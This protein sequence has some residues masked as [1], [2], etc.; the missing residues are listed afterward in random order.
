ML[1]VAVDARVDAYLAHA[2]KR[3]VGGESWIA[4]WSIGEMGTVEVSSAV[5][6]KPVGEKNDVGSQGGMAYFLRF[7]AL[8]VSLADVKIFQASREKQRPR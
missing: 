1:G 2:R 4:S 8:G 7:E 6:G 3:S 5:A